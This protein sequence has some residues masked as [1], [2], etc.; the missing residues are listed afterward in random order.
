MHLPGGVILDPSKLPTTIGSNK[1]GNNFDPTKTV[2]NNPGQ[3]GGSG[4]GSPIK[5][6]GGIN[7]DPTKTV[8]NNP[9]QQGGS[10]SGSPIKTPGGINI[11]PTKIVTTTNN[12]PIKTTTPG[13]TTT[14][15]KDEDEPGHGGASP[16]RGHQ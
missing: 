4:S 1:G 14:D 11:D 8:T 13:T 10:G 7:I 16:G 2:T 15:P 5:T 9:G 3:L 12:N 6:P